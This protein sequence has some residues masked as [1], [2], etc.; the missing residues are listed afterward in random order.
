MKHLILVL[1]TFLMALSASAQHEP[2]LPLG[3]PAPDFTAADTLG[4]NH[5]L[6]DYANALV[7]VDFWAS[8]CGDCRREMPALKQLYE[9]YC[10]CGVE[11]VSVSFDESEASWKAYLRKQELPWLQIS[12][13]QP[14]HS[15]VDGVSTTTNP[16][17]K[18][19]DLKWIPTLFLVDHGTIIAYDTTVEHFEEKLRQRIEMKVEE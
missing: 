17:A 19:Y 7:V 9:D 6:S 5:S 2:S 15:K 13:L 16:I 1:T 11:F 18:A 8:W 4:V 14:W 12:N 3:S 10:E